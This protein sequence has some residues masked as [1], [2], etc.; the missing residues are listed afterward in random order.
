MIYTKLYN[1]LQ[2]YVFTDKITTNSM[3]IVIIMTRFFL[4]VLSLAYNEYIDYIIESL[5]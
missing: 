2:Y 5:I 3:P 1:I 4:L